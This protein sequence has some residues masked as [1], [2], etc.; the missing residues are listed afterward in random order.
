MIFIISRSV[1]D[2]RD[3]TGKKHQHLHED[4]RQR[5]QHRRTR[6]MEVGT[7]A[8]VDP[9]QV[10][11]PLEYPHRRRSS[12]ERMQLEHPRGSEALSA[13]R[14]YNPTP[15]DAHRGDQTVHPGSLASSRRGSITR[16]IDYEPSFHRLPTP[17][18]S[19]TD[20]D[21]PYQ[22]TTIA[23]PRREGVDEDRHEL[24]ELHDPEFLDMHEKIAEIGRS[25]SEKE[26]RE[27]ARRGSTRGSGRGRGR[28]RPRGGSVDSHGEGP[29]NA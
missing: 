4:A 23:H 26:R 27:L 24:H 15:Y 19:L 9:S 29:S 5:H 14:R 16:S 22:F 7:P 3:A 2:F 25:K 20:L 18:L 28:G 8:A 12:I 10:I 17:H 11:N 13:L 6:G 1:F 21:H